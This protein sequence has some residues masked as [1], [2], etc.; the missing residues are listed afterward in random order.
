MP[1]T[2]SRKPTGGAEMFDI[3]WSELAVIAAVALVVIGPKDLPKAL[4]MMGKWLRKAR[5][6]A[7]DFQSGIDDMVREAELDDLRK[8]ASAARSFNLQREVENSID[9]SGAL[10]NAFALPPMATSGTGA[11]TTTEAGSALAAE[12]AEV[13][14]AASP[15][16][17]SPSPPPPSSPSSA[18]TPPPSSAPP[19]LPSL[20]PP[21]ATPAALPQIA[22]DAIVTF[23]PSARRTASNPAEK[24]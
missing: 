8:Q 11:A 7:R 19:G 21:V 1:D 9:P 12:P 10:K 13:P 5:A 18:A 23:G 20:M 17:S 4:Y 22:D 24:G 14:S 6:L 2:R 15:P 3:G 16:P